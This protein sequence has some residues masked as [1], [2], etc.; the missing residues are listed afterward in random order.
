MAIT[1]RACDGRRPG[2]G[3]AAM[4]GFAHVHRRDANLGFSPTGCLLER[5]LKVVTQISPAIDIRMSTASAEEIAEYVAERV[6]KTLSARS[7][8]AGIDARMAMLVVCGS[9]PWVR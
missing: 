5:N 6:G 9:L 8:H 7:T 2:L 4:A 3:A 1:G